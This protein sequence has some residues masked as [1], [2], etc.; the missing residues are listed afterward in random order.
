LNAKGLLAQ[1]ERL[2]LSIQKIQWRPVNDAAYFRERPPCQ[3]LDFA[4]DI[5]G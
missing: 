5:P 2:S 3:W 1:P 4:I